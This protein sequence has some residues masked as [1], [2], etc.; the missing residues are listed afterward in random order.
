MIELNRST[1]TDLRRF[2]V[3]LRQNRESERERERDS[4]VFFG[5]SPVLMALTQ[6]ETR[7]RRL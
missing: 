7:F 3:D 2:R 1:T 5:F 4:G 6:S